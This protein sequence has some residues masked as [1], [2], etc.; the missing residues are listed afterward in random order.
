MFTDIVGYTSLSSQN[1]QDALDF[2]ELNSQLHDY[3]INLHHGSKLKEI[4]DG[5]LA[6][7]DS[8]VDAANCAIAIQQY[9]THYN[10]Y[11]LR[12][13]LHIGDVLAC[14]N[15]VLGN[16]VNI[17]ARIQGATEP[18][19]IAI[20]DVLYQSIS[21][22]LAFNFHEIGE[23][24]LKGIIS[25]FHLYEITYAPI[26]PKKIDLKKLPF[27]EKQSFL[28]QFSSQSLIA[29]VLVISLLVLYF[30]YV[31]K[32]VNNSNYANKPQQISSIAVLPFKDLTEVQNQQYFSDGISE[33][34]LNSLS[35]IKGLNVSS[36]LSS[37]SFNR[38][39]LDLKEIGKR[40]NVSHILE[41]SVQRFDNKMRISAQLT[42]IE[43]GFQKWSETYDRNVAD[44]FV[45]QDDIAKSVITA[46]QNIIDS[47]SLEDITPKAIDNFAAYDLYLQGLS[48]LNAP[49]NVNNLEQA[50]HY[51][52]QA[53]SKEPSYASAYAGLC[54]TEV[55][56]YLENNNNKNIIA[57]TSSCIKSLEHDP[58]L[59]DVHVAL[60]KFHHSTG[61]FNDSLAS[62][63]KA[64][65]ILPKH[66]DAMIGIADTYISLNR[67]DNASEVLYQL[68][69]MTPNAW[70]A[71][72]ELGRLYLIK[73][74][75]KKAIPP[76][77]KVIELFPNNESA[78]SNLGY[79]YFYLHDFENAKR[80]WLAALNQERSADSYSNLGMLYYQLSDFV[81]AEEMFKE[82][83]N[84]SPQHS[85][86]WGNLADVY[87]HSNQDA[88]ALTTYRIAID[89]AEKSLENN[90][91]D[92]DTLSTL[93]LYHARINEQSKAKSYLSSSLKISPDELNVLYYAALVNFELN[94]ED[95]G[96]QYLN[97]AIN[98]GYPSELI[99]SSPDFSSKNRDPRFIALIKERPQK[100][101]VQ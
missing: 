82:A 14:S 93:S 2:L 42:E 31:T 46:L 10:K 22:Q 5:T 36:R 37:F 7:F 68:I 91:I 63:E 29:S 87:F 86:F 83:V 47:D 67:Y 78:Y 6:T 26:T 85:L 95:L 1:E 74:E 54:R 55:N 41:G 69:E 72:N 89:K 70:S 79:A 59:I 99:K 49:R 84:L 27:R 39:E 56:Q 13:G 28:S 97:Q 45:I 25:P 77:E 19:K 80:Y 11:Q 66:F 33:E 32:P 81:K 21:N 43:S 51:F 73:G 48:Y 64:L 50:K 62:F 16:S 101:S 76:F 96:W 94:N 35:K 92:I 15:D 90:E 23:V 71:H 4:G 60:G 98:N 100:T 30:L 38:D 75:M 88:K 8:A 44:I 20:S 57:A 17:C 52:E 40:L 65:S 18:D 34:L 3:L 61:R 58:N 53:I 9:V 24:Y 12:I